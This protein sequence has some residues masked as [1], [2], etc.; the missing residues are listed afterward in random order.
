MSRLGNNC[1]YWYFHKCLYLIS[2]IS[3]R[4]TKYLYQFNMFTSGIWVFFS[5]YISIA[6]HITY[7]RSCKMSWFNMPTIYMTFRDIIS[8]A[9]AQR[10][11]FLLKGLTGEKSSRREG[12]QLKLRVNT[13][14]A[15]ST[16]A[17]STQQD[18]HIYTHTRAPTDVHKHQTSRECAGDAQQQ[19]MTYSLINFSFKQQTSHLGAYKQTQWDALMSML[20]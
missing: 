4:E 15:S 19:C 5:R 9:T 6:R 14:E 10:T 13:D 2:N 1:S 7:M 3:P 20:M 11:L 8:S 12:E 17:V 18:I 16:D